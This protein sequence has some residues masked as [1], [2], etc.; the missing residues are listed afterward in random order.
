MICVYRISKGGVS[1]ISRQIALIKPVVDIA[2]SLLVEAPLLLFVRQFPSVRNKSGILVL[3]V[4]CLM[5]SVGRRLL[6]G[7][8]GRIRDVRACYQKVPIDSP[9]Q[10]HLEQHSPFE[11]YCRSVEPVYCVLRSEC[12]NQLN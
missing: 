10:R 6:C 8:V 2:C 11:I 7:S 1:N 5:V 3:H 4:S 9:K 12:V